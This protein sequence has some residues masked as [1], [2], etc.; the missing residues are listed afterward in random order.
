MVAFEATFVAFLVSL[1]GK[2]EFE[3]GLVFC[4]GLIQAIIPLFY[5]EKEMQ[6]IQL[7]T[8]YLRLRLKRQ[9]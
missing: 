4:K 5:S 2:I 6:R 9:T 7:A 3:R 8:D 1:P